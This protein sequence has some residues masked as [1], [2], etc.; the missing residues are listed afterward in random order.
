[1]AGTVSTQDIKRYAEDGV[2]HIP[3]ALGKRWL[4]AAEKCFNWS[5]D[6]P[7]PSA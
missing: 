1:M 3:K 4:D 6:N 5:I 2:I 7:T